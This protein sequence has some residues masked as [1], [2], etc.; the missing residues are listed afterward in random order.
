MPDQ[1]EAGTKALTDSWH[2]FWERYT[3]QLLVLLIWWK[4]IEKD[5]TNVMN[6]EEKKRKEHFQEY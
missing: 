6:T 2:Q 5:F 1:K 4:N 3:S